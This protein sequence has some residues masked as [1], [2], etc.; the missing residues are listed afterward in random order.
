MTRPSRFHDFWQRALHAARSD[1]QVFPL[2][3]VRLQRAL[4]CRHV[5]H[6]PLTHL[7]LVAP[8]LRLELRAISQKHVVALGRLAVVLRFTLIKIEAANLLVE[9]VFRAVAI[10]KGLHEFVFLEEET[11]RLVLLW[12]VFCELAMELG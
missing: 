4:P 1:L 3:L 9:L 5:R 6:F 10:A 8:L 11:A 12:S 7:P 2:L